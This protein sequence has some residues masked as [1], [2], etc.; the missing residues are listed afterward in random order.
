[1]PRFQRRFNDEARIVAQLRYGA[2]WVWESAIRVV[3]AGKKRSLAR[4]GRDVYLAVPL[5]RAAKFGRDS[6]EFNRFARKQPA[7]AEAYDLAVQGSA[8]L[9]TELQA[10][11]LADQL[12]S[13]IGIKMHLGELAVEAYEKLFFNIRGQL[14]ASTFVLRSAIGVH[15]SSPPSDKQAVLLGGYRY[16]TVGVERFLDWYDSRGESNDLS[17]HRGRIN[18]AIDLLISPQTF[19]EDQTSSEIWCRWLKIRGVQSQ[20]MY[21]QRSVRE[22]MSTN[23]MQMLESG[24]ESRCTDESSQSHTNH[25]EFS[26]HL[27]T[28]GQSEN[29]PVVA[30]PQR[31]IAP[32][33]H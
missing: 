11:I 28:S 1:M 30:S 31:V 15:P 25:T 3:Q 32:L 20:K 22:A 14:G 19:P 7:L 5:V 6:L 2:T 10:R 17:S 12:P 29:A 9:Q 13:L 16:G 23:L 8:R 4:D 33:V 24:M 21:R 27:V 26:T 18:E